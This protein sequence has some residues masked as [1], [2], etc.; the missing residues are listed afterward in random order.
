M[1]EELDE[2]KYQYEKALRVKDNLLKNMERRKK[3]NLLGSD[4]ED[5]LKDDIAEATTQAD[6]LK[7]QMRSLESR[8]ARARTI[9]ETNETSPWSK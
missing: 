1:K 9:A 3:L 6:D 8:Y 5:S 2:L 4:E 7:R